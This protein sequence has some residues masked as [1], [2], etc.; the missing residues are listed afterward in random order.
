MK[1]PQ[2]TKVMLT[3]FSTIATMLL[4]PNIANSQNTDPGLP[5]V[6]PELVGMSSE[7]LARIRPAM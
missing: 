7:R 6:S 3:V 5:T 4:L 2:R 1:L